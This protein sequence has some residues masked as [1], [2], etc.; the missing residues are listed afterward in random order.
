MSNQTETETK[1]LGSARKAALDATTKNIKR[2]VQVMEA[3]HNEIEETFG[4]VGCVERTSDA[5]KHEM[6]LAIFKKF[7]E[8]QNAAE[9][10]ALM[11]EQI[12]LTYGRGY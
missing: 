5:Q 10:R 9:H 11:S 3:I 4:P 8:D 2:Y 6:T 12:K 1:K 7:F